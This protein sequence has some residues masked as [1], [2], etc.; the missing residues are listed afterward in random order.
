MTIDGG[1][2]NPAKDYD[3]PFVRRHRLAKEAANK[4]RTTTADAL[5]EKRE[6]GRA[7]GDQVI[8]DVGTPRRYV[9][10]FPI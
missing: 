2:F 3:D 4:L 6:I 8:E 9:P 7:A 10:D 1:I 5:T